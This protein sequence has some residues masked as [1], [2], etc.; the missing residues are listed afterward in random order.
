MKIGR[1]FL[2]L[3]IVCSM[4]FSYDSIKSTVKQSY[5]FIALEDLFVPFSFKTVVQTVVHYSSVVEI[6]NSNGKKVGVMRTKNGLVFEGHENQIVLLETY[7]N[8]CP[9]CKAAIPDYNDLKKQFPKDVYI[10]TVE[11]YGLSNAQ[12][13]QYAKNY[14]ITYDTVAKEKSGKLLQYFN[15]LGYAT[16]GVPNL[17]VLRRDGTVAK[18]YPLLA[19]F[20]KSEI[21]DLIHNL[22]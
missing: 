4:A 2:G 16:T 21:V 6:A 17:L 7:G 18:F 20:P 8:S 9:H 19:D 14:G 15:E 12:L 1:L 3:L 13:K 22:Q 11:T 10:I 5:A